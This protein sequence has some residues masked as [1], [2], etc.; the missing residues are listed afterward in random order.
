MSP[1]GLSGGAD[2]VDIDNAAGSAVHSFADTSAPGRPDQEDRRPTALSFI[3]M[4]QKQ[5]PPST[6]APPAESVPAK[7]R[8][9]VLTGFPQK[10]GEAQR[11][12]LN[13]KYVE[14]P[15]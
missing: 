9:L 10:L 3:E 11:G 5:D 6:A 13:G 12:V 15:Q 14:H 2:F 4:E 8:T 7:L 1:G